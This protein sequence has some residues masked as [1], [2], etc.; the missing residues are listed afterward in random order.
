MWLT[1]LILNFPHPL[2]GDTKMG[3]TG[4]SEV[5]VEMPLFNHHVHKAYNY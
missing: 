4:T 2:F 1:S 3:L 5:G